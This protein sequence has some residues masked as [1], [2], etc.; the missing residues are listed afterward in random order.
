MP[1]RL[2]AVE[3]SRRIVLVFQPLHRLEEDPGGERVEEGLQALPLGRRRPLELLVAQA[4]EMAAQLDHGRNDREI[5]QPGE[6][7]LQLLFDDLL[8]DGT[9]RARRAR[10]SR[11]PPRGRRWS[12]NRRCRPRRHPERCRAARPGRET[13]SGV[14]AARASRPRR[15]PA[16]RGGSGLEVALTTTSAPGSSSA[17]LFPGNPTSPDA[18]GEL[19]GA[20]EGPVH[21]HRLPDSRFDRV[22]SEERTR[23][24]RADDEHAVLARGPRTPSSRARTRSTGRR[25]D[26]ARSRSR[27]GRACP[28]RPRSRRGDA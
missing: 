24:P 9:S 10:F 4:I 23:F 13:S 18:R 3:L 2:D 11:R 8:G 14:R 1:H 22:A 26:D 17:R 28:P 5:P 12:T 25:G 16:S 7:G 27:T 19:L 20:R 21:D 6:V 15:P